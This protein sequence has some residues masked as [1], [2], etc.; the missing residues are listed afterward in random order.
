MRGCSRPGSGYRPPEGGWSDRVRSESASSERTREA[1][2]YPRRHP[3]ATGGGPCGRGKPLMKFLVDYTLGTRLRPK[4]ARWRTGCGRADAKTERTRGNGRNQWFS[5]SSVA[6]IV[7][8]WALGEV[9]IPRCAWPRPDPFAR[10]PA[11][12]TL[13]R[14]RRRDYSQGRMDRRNHWLRTTG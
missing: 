4:S 2:A 7:R 11:V 12:P 14:S 5:D 1:G 3:A 9:S 6:L 10:P 13:P 8:F